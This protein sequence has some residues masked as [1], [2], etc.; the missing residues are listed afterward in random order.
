M[1]AFQ[2]VQWLELWR[3]QSRRPKFESSWVVLFSLHFAPVHYGVHITCLRAVFDILLGHYIHK[4]CSCGKKIMVEIYRTVASW[5][6]NVFNVWLFVDCY[7][8]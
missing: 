5:K 3:C 4:N 6:D 7:E 8:L 2:T 1:V